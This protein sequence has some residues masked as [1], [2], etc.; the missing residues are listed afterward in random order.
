M[1]FSTQKSLSYISVF[2]FET[3][4]LSKYI[5]LGNIKTTTNVNRR[6]RS[7]V[8]NCLAK[9]EEKYHI[10]AYIYLLHRSEEEKK[11]KYVLHFID[12]VQQSILYNKNITS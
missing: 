5:M 3:F 11:S 9:T 1:Y 2:A 10:H 12:S 8:K 7:S 4:T 6:Q